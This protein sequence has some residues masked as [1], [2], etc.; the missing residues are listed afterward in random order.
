MRAIVTRV[1]SANVTVG[2]RDV[3]SIGHGL[4]AL[5]GICRTDTLDDLAYIV[6]KLLTTRLFADGSK[7]WSLGVKDVGGELLLVSQF[8]LYGVH[9]GTKMDWSKASECGWCER[10]R[11]GD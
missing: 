6:S 2:G 5:V 9:K 4:L 8:T 10:R 3:S 11:R 1:L 7:Q